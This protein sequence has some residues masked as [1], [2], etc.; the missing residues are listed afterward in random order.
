MIKKNHFISQRMMTATIPSHSGQYRITTIYTH[1]DNR[2]AVSYDQ[3]YT[4]DNA[5]L[6]HI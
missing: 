1:M 6:V 5:M 2:H 3:A 4:M